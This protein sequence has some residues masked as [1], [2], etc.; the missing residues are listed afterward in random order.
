MLLGFGSA[1]RVMAYRVTL[2][3]Q[4]RECFLTVLTRYTHAAADDGSNE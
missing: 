1:T 3:P 2:V 4:Q